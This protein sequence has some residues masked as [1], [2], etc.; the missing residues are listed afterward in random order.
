MDLGSIFLLLALLIVVA[1][2]VAR[3]LIDKHALLV[4]EE[5]QTISALLAERDRILDALHELDFDYRM[6]KIPEEDYPAQRTRLLNK[7][8]AVL[9]KLDA[10]HANGTNGKD[11]EL[12]AAIAARRRTL[13][14]SGDTPQPLPRPGFPDDEIE[15]LIAARRRNRTEK[16]NGFCPQCGHAVHNADRFC[17]HCGAALGN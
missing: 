14:R 12:E 17:S 15:A 6:G 5:E 11:A 16:P 3:P 8:A 10:L 7:G 4:T 2:F 9:K 1:L 13:A